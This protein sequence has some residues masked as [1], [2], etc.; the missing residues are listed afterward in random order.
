MVLYFQKL[1]R[2]SDEGLVF[3]KGMVVGVRGNHCHLLKHQL[4]LSNNDSFYIQ[5][6]NRSG[7]PPSPEWNK[8][9][10]TKYLEIL[11]REKACVHVSVGAKK[12]KKKKN[13]EPF[14][15]AIDAIC[16]VVR[17]REQEGL[18]PVIINREISRILFA[19]EDGLEGEGGLIDFYITSDA[20]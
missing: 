5:K 15:V 14:P 2:F 1:N 12:K 10:R 20:W 17:K 18:V 6:S 7:A 3:K 9:A 11:P 16:N 13:D 8:R 19:L 4:P